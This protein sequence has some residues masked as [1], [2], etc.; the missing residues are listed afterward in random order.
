MKL[1]I[2]PSVFA[3][4]LTF[5]LNDEI[6]QRLHSV[7]SAM[8]SQELENSDYDAA[9]I[10]SLDL[11]KH[12]DFF[13]SAKAAVSFDGALSNS[14]LYFQTGEK[15]ISEINLTG[16]VSANDALV[17]KMVFEEFYNNPVKISLAA[18]FEKSSGKN[19]LL[20]GNKNFEDLLFENGI[21]LAEQLSE[22]L[23]YPYVNFVFA[24]K[25]EET[26]KE[27]NKLLEKIDETVD[28]T[29]SNILKNF[30]LPEEAKK[31]IMENLNSIYFEMTRNEQEGLNELLRYAYYKGLV[32][33]MSELKFVE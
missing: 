6:L 32:E 5:N 18:N 10:P 22:F 25:Q 29:I 14:Y 13:V 15:N 31:F 3:G 20:S 30:S 8:I 16:D 4:I 9:L 1:L 11:L 24:A 26:I 7:P 27:L 12:S 33:D 17:S 28:D 21:S 19:F 23:D 2:P